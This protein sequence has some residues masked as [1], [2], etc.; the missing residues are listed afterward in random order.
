MATP[1]AAIQSQGTTL[2][3]QAAGGGWLFVGEVVSFAE[4]AQNTSIIDMSALEHTFEQIQKS[5]LIR[6][7]E[8][9]FELNYISDD[10]GQERCRAIDQDSSKGT[11]RLTLFGGQTATFAGFVMNFSVTGSVDEKVAANMTIRLT[12]ALADWS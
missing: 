10:T 9:T 7:G 6:A 4:G 8:W 2:E 12:D 1:T 3:V 11:F 5:R